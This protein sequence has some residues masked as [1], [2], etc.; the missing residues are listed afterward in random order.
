VALYI[1][2]LL[3]Y[4]GILVLKILYAKELW[5]REFDHKIYDDNGKLEKLSDVKE[6]M[7]SSESNQNN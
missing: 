2:I 6:K 7:F 5:H 1:A 3:T 4:S